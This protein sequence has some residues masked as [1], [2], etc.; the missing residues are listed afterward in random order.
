VKF[1]P[2]VAALFRGR[3][4]ALGAIEP[5]AAHR[6]A[7]FGTIALSVV[8]SGRLALQLIVLPIMARILGPADFGL[9]ALAMPFILFANMLSDAGMGNALIRRQDADRE[10]ES[11]VFW[12]CTG[13]GLTIALL[14]CLG[15]GPIAG[16]LGQPRL[17]PIL[18]GLSPILVL[19]STLSVAN[20]R[21]SR[22][23]HFGL[24]AVGDLISAVL[25]SG[26]A[27]LAALH[28]WGAWSLVVQQLALWTAKAAWILPASRFRPALVCRPSRARDLMSF[29]LHS[30]GADIAD[31]VGKSAPALV[32]GSGLGVVAVGHYSMA[33]QLIRIPDM[34]LSG[35]LY[36]ATFTAVSALAANA[37]GAAPLSM[38]TI[39]MVVSMLAPLFCGLALV[40]DLLIA[41]FLGP[42]WEGTA[43][44]LTTLAAAG[45]FLCLH[46]L[47]GAVLMGL[48][49]SDLQFRLSLLSGAGMVGGALA[50]QRFGLDAAAIG[51][52]AGAA[53]AFPFYV[54]TLSGQLCIDGRATL[55][56]IGRPLIATAVMALAV[57]VVRDELPVMAAW[58]KLAACVAA[59]VLAFAVALC[60]TSGRQMLD[61]VKTLLPARAPV[62]PEVT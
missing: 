14:I 45:F 54:M 58:L 62:R 28:G 46:S 29:G 5:A 49:R 34:V 17:A 16:L 56:A 40:A 15:S 48:G 2:A 19:S 57:L 52:T 43:P 53:L 41:A 23:R 51:V 26:A 59:G 3:R 27:I 38:R 12:L 1:G 8:N 39:R 24:F 30:V 10:I 55:S 9:V 31:F 37:A 32:I 42:K 22:A 60:A 44:V 6:R 61:D 13:V 25:S 50:G 21:I 20:A 47:F 11:T 18:I 36:L 4:P 35:P 7:F 33:Y